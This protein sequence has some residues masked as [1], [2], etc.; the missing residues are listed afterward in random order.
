MGK[1]DT[2]CDVLLADAH[3][4]VPR[5]I[6]LQR[7]APRANLGIKRAVEKQRG[8]PQPYASPYRVGPR[9]QEQGRRVRFLD[10]TADLDIL[11]N[12]PELVQV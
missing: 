5:H 6:A 11:E 2:C 10:P 7:P 12:S 4:G 3:R 1:L 8:K 9:F